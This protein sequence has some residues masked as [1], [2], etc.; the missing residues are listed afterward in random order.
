MPG[1]LI[2]IAFIAFTGI[3]I[4]SKVLLHPW[5][6][7]ILK[8]RHALELVL[9]VPLNRPQN[10]GSKAKMTSLRPQKVISRDGGQG[11]ELGW[12]IFNRPCNILASS[13]VLHSCNEGLVCSGFSSKY[14]GTETGSLMWWTQHRHLV[15]QRPGTLFP[16]RD[17]TQ[18]AW[19][20]AHPLTILEQ[21]RMGFFWNRPPPCRPPTSCL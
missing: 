8:E 20:I 15:S 17:Q 3:K 13:L 14:K 4:R 16:G 1:N 5:C 19:P 12:D 7:V 18:A 21:D 2:P 11:L 6:H 9:L 10:K